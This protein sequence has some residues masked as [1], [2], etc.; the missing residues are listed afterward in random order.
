MA[1]S[2][3]GLTEL[4]SGKSGSRSRS[5]VPGEPA[6]G[7]SAWGESAFMTGTL[8]VT[9]G[10]RE[11]GPGRPVGPGPRRGR[12]AAP[13]AASARPALARTALARTALA[14][15]ALARTG[16]GGR[17]PGDGLESFTPARLAGRYPGF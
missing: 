15:T 11:A 6:L 14:R 10:R 7:E 4:C 2:P 3:S 12:L 9:A 17:G 13:A 8:A 16:I 5:P 1:S